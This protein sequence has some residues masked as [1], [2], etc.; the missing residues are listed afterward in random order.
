MILS[1]IRLLV[2]VH[3]GEKGLPPTV[4][5]P[6]INIMSLLDEELTSFGFIPSP[7]LE[8]EAERLKNSI[9]TMNYNPRDDDEDDISDDLALDDMMADEDEDEDDDDSFL[10]TLD[11]DDDE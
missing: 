2:G 5:A 6:V 9:I 7:Q 11:D 3:L 1:D 4:L 10:S 8:K